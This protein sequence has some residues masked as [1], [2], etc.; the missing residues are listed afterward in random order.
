MEA[1]SN[2]ATK[3]IFKLIYKVKN[4]G[5]YPCS[6]WR[7]G[8]L[9]MPHF[10]RPDSRKHAVNY[11]RYIAPEA[12]KLLRFNFDRKLDPWLKK[13][14]T[15]K[16]LAIVTKMQIGDDHSVLFSLFIQFSRAEISSDF[17]YTKVMGTRLKRMKRN[18]RRLI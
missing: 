12:N 10:C 13:I 5:W 3:K 15:N 6:L 1:L 9:K 17:P 18:V 11:S 2:K 8:E 7:S 14:Q 16:F 4:S